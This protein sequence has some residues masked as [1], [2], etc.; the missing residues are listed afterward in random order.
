MRNEEVEAKNC[1]VCD[2]NIIRV[3]SSRELQLSV[4]ECNCCGIRIQRPVPEEEIVEIWNQMYDEV[5]P[6]QEK[7]N[8]ILEKHQKKTS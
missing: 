1:P 3:D 2:W 7:I 6:L 5:R 8:K 4:V